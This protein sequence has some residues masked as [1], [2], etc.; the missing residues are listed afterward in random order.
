M[1]IA[2]AL[3]NLS[4][5]IARITLIDLLSALPAPADDTPDDRAARDEAAI[6]AVAALHPEDAFEARLAA[7][8]VLTD[9]HATDC[10]RHA[11]IPGLDPG[12]ARRS[13]SQA[14]SMMRASESAQK[15]LR[16]AQLA[17][18][19]ALKELQPGEME[20][21]GYWFKDVSQPEP[22]PGE[23]AVPFEKLHEAE[24]YAVIYPER[25]RLIRANGGLPANVT[26]GPPA[27]A[28]VAAIAAGTSPILRALDAPAAVSPG[29][30]ESRQTV[31]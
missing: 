12:E 20:R 15:A 6:A 2:D 26:F 19:K 3:P 4:P 25:A 29:A 30:T 13:R 22:P 28:L 27:A 1:N 21:A 31:N 24:Q 18:D 5:A 16:A 8:A 9:A 11:A 10:L 17:R 23:P 7:R 14:S